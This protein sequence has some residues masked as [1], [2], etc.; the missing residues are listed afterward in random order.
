MRFKEKVKTN[1]KRDTLKEIYN[2]TIR[3]DYSTNLYSF[4]Y[5]VLSEKD[6]DINKEILTFLQQHRISINKN[7]SFTNEELLTISY[8]APFYKEKIRHNIFE[9]NKYLFLIGYDV[10]WY[11]TL[12]TTK[13]IYTETA[14]TEDFNSLAL[15][16]AVARKKNM[17]DTKFFNNFLAMEQNFIVSITTK[18]AY[19][20]K[21][22]CHE[23]THCVDEIRADGW[24][25]GYG[26]VRLR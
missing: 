1:D 19:C 11:D 25:V 9:F 6:E 3:I 10:G 2:E 8:L 16:I 24:D 23:V 21:F 5:P 26:K 20:K 13:G 15:D 7:V 12:N 4:L 14:L 17:L 18:F 22:W